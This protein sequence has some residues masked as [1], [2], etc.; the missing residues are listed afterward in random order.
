LPTNW[1][2]HCLTR[3][4][5]NPRL[6]QFPWK[7][8]FVFNSSFSGTD[9]FDS[10]NNTIALYCRPLAVWDELERSRFGWQTVTG[11]VDMTSAVKRGRAGGF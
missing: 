5:K 9:F 10:L 1:V 3:L 4:S 8:S 7:K 11:N 6:H 2:L